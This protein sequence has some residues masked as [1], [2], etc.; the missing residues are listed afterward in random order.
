MPEVWAF[1]LIFLILCVSLWSVVEIAIKWLVFDKMLPWDARWQSLLASI[2]IQLLQ[3][4]GSALALFV[5]NYLLKTNLALN[6]TTDALFLLVSY[7]VMRL[8]FNTL[9]GAFILFL[10][11]KDDRRAL[12]ASV[13]SNLISLVLIV[14]FSTAIY[15]SIPRQQQFP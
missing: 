9:I 3:I 10:V 12:T 11:K 7:L 13:V 2:G 8:V 15:L 14:F 5:S 4:F 6:S 1:G